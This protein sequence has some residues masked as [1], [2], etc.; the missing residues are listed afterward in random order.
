[1]RLRLLNGEERSTLLLLLLRLRRGGAGEGRKGGV[2]V[3]VGVRARRWLALVVLLLLRLLLLLVPSWRESSPSVTHSPTLSEACPLRLQ[4]RSRS[5][6]PVA[7]LLRL[8]EASILLLLVLRLLLLWL[9]LVELL[10][11][12][13]IRIFGQDVGEALSCVLQLRS[14]RG[15]EW[16]IHR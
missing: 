7:C 11:L 4:V 15:C 16:I 1:M 3:Q 14:R 9:L 2:G 6:L 13:K 10:R 5:L 8:L 12:A